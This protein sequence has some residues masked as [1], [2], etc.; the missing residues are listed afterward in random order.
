MEFIECI[1]NN[2]GSTF[3]IDDVVKVI[4]NTDSLSLGDNN[5]IVKEVKG[6][7]MEINKE[8]ITIDCSTLFNCNLISM[9][10]NNIKNICWA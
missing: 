10:K 6:R 7:L 9:D 5:N 1:K 3:M 4:L 2:D 8:R